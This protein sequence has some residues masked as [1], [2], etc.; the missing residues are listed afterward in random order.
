[1]RFPCRR[2]GPFRGE[3]HA[4]RLRADRVRSPD[5]RLLR[6]LHRAMTNSRAVSINDLVDL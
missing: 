6:R 2:P 1:M 3:Q 4:Y 5:R